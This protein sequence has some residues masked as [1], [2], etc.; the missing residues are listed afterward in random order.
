M[1]FP[2][3]DNHRVFPLFFWSRSPIYFTSK[4][5]NPY[6]ERGLHVGRLSPEDAE[7]FGGLESCVADLRKIWDAAA[8]RLAAALPEPVHVCF[9]VLSVD[10][11]VRLKI[12]K[13]PV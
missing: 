11:A 4:S 3:A 6:R 9:L 1:K 5:I 12:V 10:R 13:A 8:Y 2:K 7:L